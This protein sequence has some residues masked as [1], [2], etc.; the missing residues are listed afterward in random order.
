MRKSSLKAGEILRSD[1]VSKDEED[2]AGVAGT[3][4]FGCGVSGE[5]IRKVSHVF[6]SSSSRKSLCVS[7]LEDLVLAQITTV[8]SAC[9]FGSGSVRATSHQ[10]SK[11]VTSWVLSQPRESLR[12]SHLTRERT[13]S[14]RVVLLGPLLLF[15][16]AKKERRAEVISLRSCSDNGSPAAR[17]SARA[18]MAVIPLGKRSGVGGTEVGGALEGLSDEVM[19]EI[20][21][22]FA[23]DSIE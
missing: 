4:L 1:P 17:R 11:T 9:R 5:S 3:G 10:W 2:E 6:V 16:D 12:E 15:D 21:K 23:L 18:T 19:D 13:A 14:K 8:N 22:F 20:K 7:S